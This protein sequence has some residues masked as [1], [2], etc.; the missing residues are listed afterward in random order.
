MRTDSFPSV[1]HQLA[2]QGAVLKALRRKIKYAMTGV[3]LAELVDREIA[4]IEARLAMN[5]S[6]RCVVMPALGEIG[7]VSQ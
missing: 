5:A 6:A 1:A 4:D 3:Q 7:A 2:G